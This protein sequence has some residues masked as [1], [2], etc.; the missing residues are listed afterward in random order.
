[1]GTSFLE[2]IRVNDPTSIKILNLLPH[3]I[4][5]ETRLDIFRD[6][7]KTSIP[8]DPDAPGIVIRVRRDHV[9]DDGYKHLGGKI[10]AKIKGRIRVKFVNETGKFYFFF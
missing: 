8:N 6:Y 3:T 7:L 9:L 10:A 4:P 1:M 2:R 5:C